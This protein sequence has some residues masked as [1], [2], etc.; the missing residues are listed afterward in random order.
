MVVSSIVQEE[1]C[2]DVM[3]GDKIAALKQCLYPGRVVECRVVIFAFLY[4]YFHE[5]FNFS[6]SISGSGRKETVTDDT[7]QEV[8][9]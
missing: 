4:M 7:G 8:S 1:I 6:A 3:F 9:W 2:P 5:T